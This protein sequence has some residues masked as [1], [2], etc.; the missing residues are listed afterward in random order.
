M[1]RGLKDF[2]DAL[3]TII[4]NEIRAHVFKHQ[5]S[6]KKDINHSLDNLYFRGLLW[7]NDTLYNEKVSLNSLIRQ[8]WKTPK[9]ILNRSNKFKPYLFR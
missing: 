1:K 7:G 3:S 5:L 9:K 2:I 6:H 8:K 4:C